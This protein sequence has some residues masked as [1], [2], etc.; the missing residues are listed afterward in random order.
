MLAIPAFSQTSIYFIQQ[1]GFPTIETTPLQPEQ[2]RN[3]IPDQAENI[4]VLNFN[5]FGQLSFDNN[6]NLLIWPYGSAMTDEIWPAVFR[7]LQ[8]GNN[9]LVTGGRA[10]SF[11]VINENGQYIPKQVTNR[12]TE[13]IRIIDTE[14]IP[15][16]N[17]ES[18]SFNSD[19]SFL[20]LGSI[21]EADTAYSLLAMMSSRN[22]YERDGSLASIDGEWKSLAAG[23]T[24]DGLNKYP[25]ISQFD[26]HREEFAGGR[27]VMMTYQPA[28]P[29]VWSTRPGQKLL[30]TLVNQSLRKPLALRIDPGYAMY[31]PGESLNLSV[32]VESFEPDDTEYYLE[33]M[34]DRDGHRFARYTDNFTAADTLINFEG[35]RS[36]DAGMYTIHLSVRKDNQ[37]IEKRESGFL[38]GKLSVLDTG[39]SWGTNSYYLTRGG[40]SYPVTGM[41]YMASDVHRYYFIHPN[42]AVWDQDMQKMK[43]NGVNMLRT[44]VWTGQD[45]IMD[46][47]DKPI[48]K[49]MRAF[50]AYFALAKKHD[51]PVQFCFFH[52]MPFAAGG[53]AP[54]SDPQAIEK[55]KA[56]ITAFT[57]RYKNNPDIIWDLINEPTYGKEGTW[58]QDNTP[59]H[60]P[61][62]IKLWNEWLQENY[63]DDWEQLASKW[64][65]VKE[66][67]IE[68]GDFILPDKSHFNQRNVYSESVKPLPTYDYNL[69]A[70]YA[71]NHWVRQI[72]QA[73]RGT[74][75][76]QMVITGQDEGGVRSRILNQFYAEESPL[77]TIH[78]WWSHDDLLWD[79]ITGKPHGMP[80]LVQETGNMRY[81]GLR[82]H[83]RLSE[84]QLA[85]SLERK[86]CLGIGA[87]AAGAIPWTWNLN[88]YMYNE[89]EVFI[90]LHRGD[91]TAKDELKVFAGI[92]EFVQQTKDYFT[93]AKD[94]DVLLVLPLALQLTSLSGQAV[95]AT[96]NAVRALHYYARIPAQAA[97]EY[98]LERHE[99]APKLAILPSPT[100]LTDQAW[101]KLLEWVEKGT[102]LLTTGPVDR[103]PHFE[104]VRRLASFG[105]EADAIPIFQLKSN[106]K[107][108]QNSEPLSL[109]YYGSTPMASYDKMSWVDQS[110]TVRTIDHGEGKILITEYPVELNNN[111]STVASLYEFAAEIAELERSF[112]ITKD[113]PGVLVRPMEFEEARL[114]LILSESDT[115]TDLQLLDQPSGKTY[116]F[117]IEPGRAQLLMIQKNT[118][119]ILGKYGIGQISIQ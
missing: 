40:K 119:N 90:G 74:G 30:N 11:D 69:F 9:L 24:S 65:M 4:Q 98:H 103:N 38:C 92:A 106:L 89:N 107:L 25:L 10:F 39:A 66:K 81:T 62:E 2:L 35:N 20:E 28:D 93:P 55:Q 26:R 56:Y 87:N 3:A 1:P 84:S 12:F 49:T 80:L 31:Y 44:G 58:W 43:K 42:P 76:N 23:N 105:I 112:Q 46:V 114:Y 73:I 71:Y 88:V 75:S 101:T 41:T 111:L 100:V 117:S 19:F 36:L 113:N 17:Q 21:P 33:I 7:F 83:S 57:D 110:G 34:V 104:K 96:Q 60:D 108:D 54:Y 109:D 37:V 72:K 94:E 53:I 99:T 82:D 77:V 97:S 116:Q 64:N 51:L 102:T 45:F 118:G 18:V 48:E 32:S 61:S 22:F 27:W 95:R 13:Q 5:Q 91:N 78:S 14:A 79:N 68:E 50:D 85:H 63:P 29:Q 115:N 8:A 16:D 6:Q 86:V 52:M 70:N 59:T 47:Q 15:V 67:T